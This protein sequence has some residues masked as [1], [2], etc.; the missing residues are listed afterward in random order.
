MI[1]VLFV[2]YDFPFPLNS[3]GKNRAYHLMKYAVFEDISVDLL[4]F[5]REEFDPQHVNEMKEI[6]IK[7]VKVFKRKK[8]NSL[9]TLAKNFISGDSIFKTLYYDDDFFNLL[10]EMVV[11]GD[12]DIVHFESSYTGY[13]IGKD[14]K[15]L[16]VKQVLGTENIEYLLY[17]EF[18]NRTKNPLKKP[19]ISYQISRLKKEEEKMMR[20]SDLTIAVTSEEA[21]LISAVS[22][23]ECRVVE[24]AVD[25]KRFEFKKRS[26]IKNNILFVGNFLYVPNIE[27]IKLFI[28]EVL[29]LLN[30]ET[31]LTVI[32]KNV[33]KVVTNL[34]QVITKEFAEDIIEEYRNADALVFPVKIG[35]GT[36]FKLLEAMA[37]GLPVI[38]YPDR[39]KSLRAESGKEFIGVLT[40]KDFADEIIKVT[41]D[42]MYG[43]DITENARKL[44]E[45]NYSWE[46][47]GGKLAR[48][49]K[50]LYERKN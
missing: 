5:V 46:K 37:L 19:I 38:A 12:I 43:K 15:K 34:D 50:G 27:A 23:K 32:G 6:G 13:Y 42:K 40:G 31:T 14:L 36:N 16:N 2:T 29:P 39:L 48:I 4:S 33:Y 49:W 8:V 11:E 24:N 20:D 1:K 7:R 47:V 26:E 9:F 17:E 28:K 3:G 10:K 44:V 41:T 30:K 25:I 21:S 18:K 22:G 45:D 35:G